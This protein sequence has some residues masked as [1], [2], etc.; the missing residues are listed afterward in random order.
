MTL[1]PRLYPVVMAAV[2]LVASLAACGEPTASEALPTGLPRY[3]LLGS[4]KKAVGAKRATTLAQDIT[5]SG[6]IGPEGGAIRIKETGFNVIFPARAVDRPVTITVTA[7]AGNLL[8]Y[9]FQPHG[10]K[11]N[12]P[13]KITQRLFGV[14]KS[15]PLTSVFLGYYPDPTTLD[16]ATGTAVI[17]EAIPAE[18]ALSDDLIRTTI[19]HFSGY[20]VATDCLRSEY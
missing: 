8:A 16:P 4:P 17:T 9:E 3:G 2:A 12:M 18:V 10:M 6:V 15:S 20:L 13:V 11:F 5:V 19:W 14:D 1:K 7:K